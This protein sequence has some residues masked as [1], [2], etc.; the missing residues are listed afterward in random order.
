MA[1]LEPRIVAHRERVIEFD[2]LLCNTRCHSLH[3]TVGLFD[4]NEGLGLLCP[5]CIASGP[6]GA[7]MRARQVPDHDKDLVSRVARLRYWIPLDKLRAVE[8]ALHAAWL[9]S[10]GLT[11]LRGEGYVVDGH[12]KPLEPSDGA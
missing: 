11:E 12:T 8:D 1:G 3:A 5:E 7:A 4:L 6:L 9:A 2:C 10:I